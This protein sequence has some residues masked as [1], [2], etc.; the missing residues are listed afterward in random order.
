MYMVYGEGLELIGR[1]FGVCDDILEI[2]AIELA[3]IYKRDSVK[4]F[5]TLTSH[6]RYSHRHRRGII[7]GESGW[8]RDLNNKLFLPGSKYRYRGTYWPTVYRATL[9]HWGICDNIISHNNSRAD[10]IKVLDD[11]D[12]K[13]KK[14]YNRVKMTQLLLSR[15]CV[16]N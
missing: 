9:S 16:N 7:C 3:H 10:L 1:N 4:L 5:E 12:I 11:N 8:H 6:M 13:Y 15:G 2:I 14:A